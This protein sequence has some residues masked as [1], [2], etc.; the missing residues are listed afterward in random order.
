[1]VL[2]GLTAACTAIMLLY[3]SA[4]ETL[5]RLAF[6]AGFVLKMHILKINS[7]RCSCSRC[8]VFRLGFSK[9]KSLTLHIEIGNSEA[10]FTQSRS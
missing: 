10:L 2:L 9:D 4:G 6:F 8:T 1:M 7:V 3:R 5:G